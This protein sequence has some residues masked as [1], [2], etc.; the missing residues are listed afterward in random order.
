VTEPTTLG[1]YL[2]AMRRRRRVSIE[3]AAED[4]RIRADFLMRMESDEFDFLAPAYVRGFLKSYSRYLGIDPEP[5]TAEFDRRYGGGRVDTSQLVA[6]QR[7]GRRRVPREP[8]KLNPVALG[9]VAIAGSLGVLALVGLITGPDDK[10][11][12]ERIAEARSSAGATLT[13][14]PSL[15]PSPSPTPTGTAGALVLDDGIE[16]EIVAVRDQCW[17]DVTADGT[18]VFK[19]LLAEGESAGP[20]SANEDIGIVLGN[21][22]GV[23][24]IINGHRFGPVGGQGEVRTIHLPDD[25]EALT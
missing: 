15:E 6:L 8:I 11:I 5:M 20:F 9:I 14:T 2:R 1:A 13:S 21:A 4:T 22:I 19:D 18:N 23:D 16:V 17:V 3:R 24:I 7:R 25:I 12:S 10:R